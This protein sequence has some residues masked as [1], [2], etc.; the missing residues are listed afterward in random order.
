MLP[1]VAL[2]FLMGRGGRSVVFSELMPDASLV[3]ALNPHGTYF[4]MD[5]NMHTTA[6]R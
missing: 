1:C 5:V 4:V 2:K 3:A 6:K